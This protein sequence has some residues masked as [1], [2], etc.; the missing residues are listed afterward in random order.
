MTCKTEKGLLLMLATGTMLLF[1]TACNSNKA[2]NDV[3]AQKSQTEALAPPINPSPAPVVEI[4]PPAPPLND[5]QR[6]ILNK[7][8]MKFQRRWY[9]A[10][11]DIK[12]TAVFDELKEFEKNFFAQTTTVENWRGSLFSAG[13]QDFGD[14]ICLMV[15]L[16]EYM[17]SVGVSQGCQGSILSTDQNGIKKGT[18]VYEQLGNFADMD[19]AGVCVQFSGKINPSLDDDNDEMAAMHRPSYIMTFTSIEKCPKKKKA[20]KQ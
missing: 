2:E 20:Q 18:A 17:D 7:T 8:I 1:F 11:N 15:D 16:G 5:D 3:S 14:D 13:K 12:R 9:D 4:Q 6:R 19:D 10:P